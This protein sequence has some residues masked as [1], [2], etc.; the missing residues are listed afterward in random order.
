MKTKR[1]GFYIYY[2]KIF[3]SS[4][5][6]KGFAPGRVSGGREKEIQEKNRG[7]ERAWGM[8]RGEGGGDLSYFL[9][10]W[11]C[12]FLFVSWGLRKEALFILGPFCATFAFSFRQWCAFQSLRVCEIE[13]LP[14]WNR[15]AG[16]RLDFSLIAF[17]LRFPP[18]NLII[19]LAC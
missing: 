1:I 11:S 2:S 4:L 6:P 9:R 13:N 19:I 16:L 18:I 15:G 12:H 5:I 10:P 3:F 17:R 14:S 7:R 8:T